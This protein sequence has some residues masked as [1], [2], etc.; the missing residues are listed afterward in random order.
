MNGEIGA[1]I[2]KRKKKALLRFLL[3]VF[4]VVS[5]LSVIFYFLF[6]YFFV[7]SKIE[8]QES[9]LYSQEAILEKS[10]LKNGVSLLQVSKK[11]AKQAIEENFPFLVNVK[12]SVSLPNRVSVSYREDFGEFA[13]EMGDHVFAVNRDLIVLSAQERNASIQRIRLQCQSVMR[14]IVGEELIF[15]EENSREG[16]LLLIE[17]LESQ[18][19]LQDVSSIDYRDKFLIR[20]RYLN[21]FDLVLG[22]SEDLIYKFAMAK[23]V[24]ADLEPNSAG[25]IDV[26]D[27]NTAYVKLDEH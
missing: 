13:L 1:Y 2:A 4:L 12:V 24:I 11:E 17:A 3:L 14:C 10:G 21:R 22:E 27:P 20:I 15:S 8:I 16:L 26:S 25:E 23:G 9:S 5:L 18:S 19:M 6:R 7:V